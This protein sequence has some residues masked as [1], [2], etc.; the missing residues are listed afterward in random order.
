MLIAELLRWSTI[1]RLNTNLALGEGSPNR[2]TETCWQAFVRLGHHHLSGVTLSEKHM[3][4]L[5]QEYHIICFSVACKFLCH[6]WCF[7]ALRIE[8]AEVRHR[9]GKLTCSILIPAM[10]SCTCRETRF[11]VSTVHFRDCYH[12]QI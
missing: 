12:A 8:Q 10:I 9:G 2:Q 7:R 5:N 1:G 11:S 6:I 3:S 4:P